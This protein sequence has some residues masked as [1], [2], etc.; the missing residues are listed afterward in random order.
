MLQIAMPQNANSETKATQQ[1]EILLHKVI[2][3]NTSVK[4]KARKQNEMHTKKQE[5]SRM[6]ALTEKEKNENHNVVGKT[7]L[8]GGESDN[9]WS[10]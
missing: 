3:C 6:S 1:N 5:A 4:F 8:H 2:V 9:S 10:P 7:P